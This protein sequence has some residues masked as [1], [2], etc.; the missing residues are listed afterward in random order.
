M[1]S[2][3]AMHERVT[4]GLSRAVSPASGTRDNARVSS[5][6]SVVSDVAVRTNPRGPDL[7]ASPAFIFIIRCRSVGAFCL[8]FG[9]CRNL[10]KPAMRV[11]VSAHVSLS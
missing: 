2:F 3:A 7:S 5:T 6:V 8:L 9:Y 4:G 1:P 10:R 11:V